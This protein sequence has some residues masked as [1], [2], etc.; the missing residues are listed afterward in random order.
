MKSSFHLSLLA[1]SLL[2]ISCEPSRKK[3]EKISEDKYQP[4][5]YV[6]VKHPEWSKSA[7]IYEVNIR[8]YTKEGTFKAFE[9]HLPRLKQMGVDI[10][11]LMPI[12]PI[13]VEKRKGT[14]GSEYSIKDY[15]GVNPEFGTKEDFRHLVNKVHSMGMHIIIDWVANHS[16]WDNTLAKEHPD[17]YSKTPEGNFQP[18]PWYDWDDVI[19]FDYDQP[20]LRQYMTEALVYWVKEFDIDGYRCDTAGFIP[21]D[22]WNNA[23]AE[24]D[25]VK[26]VFML[27][28]WESRDLHEY[29][30]DATYSWSLWN[31]MTAVTKDGKGI[32]QLVEYLAHDESTFPKG[33]YRMLFTDNHDKNSWEG[34]QIENFGPALKASMVLCATI[35]GMPLCY[36]GQE[37]GLDRSLKFFDKDEIDWSKLPYAP[38]YK[39]LFDLKHK[40]KALWNGNDGGHMIRIYNDKLDKVISFSRTKD[41]NHVISVVN[42]SKEKVA[43]KLDSKYQKGKY[44]DV[45]SG[46][47]IELK[48]DDVFELEAWGY[49]ILEK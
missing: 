8:Q 40:N 6:K 15:Y 23:R 31:A 2:M 25:A 35:N 18:T 37:A 48:G 26:P 24:M 38:L 4:Q 29:A 22:F 44:K 3:D 1:L 30:F 32:G 34:N 33:G 46:K 49:L 13:G 21:T 17:W 28:E 14:L 10:V 41:D 9:S 16:A 11:W 36:G 19:D 45:F 27:G 12:H 5:E 47:E 20:G 42:Y 7:T 43:V 39:T